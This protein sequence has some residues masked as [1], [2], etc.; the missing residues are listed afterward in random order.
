MTEP[1]SRAPERQRPGSAAD[2]R[3]WAKLLWSVVGITVAAVAIT[4]AVAGLVI[5]G[6][7]IF[8]TSTGGSIWSNK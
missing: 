7:L 8:I 5:L 4:L 6:L 1:L 3:T 2:W